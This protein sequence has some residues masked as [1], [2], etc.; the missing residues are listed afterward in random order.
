MA[1]RKLAK[2]KKVRR[3]SNVFNIDDISS[4]DEWILDD[5]NNDRVLDI[6]DEVQ[7]NIDPKKDDE[8]L[9]PNQVGEDEALSFSSN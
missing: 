2:P 4:D 7:D 3:K 6:E 5:V 9:V 1:N 8:G